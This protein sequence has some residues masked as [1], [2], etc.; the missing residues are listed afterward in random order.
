MSSLADDQAHLLRVLVRHGVEFVVIG[1]VAAQ[2]SGWN[3]ATVDLDIAVSTEASNVDRLNAALEAVGAAPGAIGGTGTSF[4]TRFG[5]LEVVR[6]ADGIGGY[7]EWLVNARRLDFE[8]L[9][10]VVAAPA[11][12]LRSKEAA[13]RDKDRQAIPAM[14][15]SFEAAGLLDAAE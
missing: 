2:L 14:R 9:T 7:S 12:I 4:M 10:I 11:D 15:R 5:R 6:R 3:G 13:G 1:G 8:T